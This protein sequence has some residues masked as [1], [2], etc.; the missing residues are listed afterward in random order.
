MDDLSDAGKPVEL[1][2]HEDKNSKYEV[3][4]TNVMAKGEYK[5]PSCYKKAA[6][7]LFSWAQD[8]FDMNVKK[9][10]DELKEVFENEFNYKVMR[11]CL[12]PSSPTEGT[13]LQSNVSYMIAQF[14]HE[15]DE[16]N[17]L[18]IIYYAVSNIEISCFACCR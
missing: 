6:V 15:F 10:V 1:T 3:I 7:L 8:V 18:L 9:E 5:S 12:R 13:S 4:F 17:S 16:P 14:I 2:E 11:E